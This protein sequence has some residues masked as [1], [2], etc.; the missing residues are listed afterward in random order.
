M[1][2]AMI[3]GTAVSSMADIHAA[4]AQELAFPDWYGGNLDALHDCL[5]ALREEAT[6]TLVYGE[7]L[8]ETLGPAY[9]RLCRVLSDSAAEN[10]Y[11]NI[12][13]E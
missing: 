9:A 3:D 12:Q 7:M 8:M 4:L 1:K 5:T 11:L 13:L 10:P 2:H 6:I